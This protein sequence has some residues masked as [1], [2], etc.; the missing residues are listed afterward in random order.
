LA[1]PVKIDLVG[2]EQL[3]PGITYKLE[4]FEAGGFT[5][6]P[7]WVGQNAQQDFGYVPYF[8]VTRTVQPATRP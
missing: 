2:G 7:E 3:Q 1:E 5:G 6:Y 4:G 8:V